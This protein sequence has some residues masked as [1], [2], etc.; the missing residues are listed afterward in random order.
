MQ[1]PNLARAYP[2]AQFKTSTVPYGDQFGITDALSSNMTLAAYVAY[3]DRILLAKTIA[4]AQKSN[5]N[6]DRTN[7]ASS[8]SITAIQPPQYI[9][10]K[11]SDDISVTSPLYQEIAAMHTP[12]V[13]T[14]QHSTVQFYLGAVGTGAPFHFHKDAYNVRCAFSDSNLHSRMPSDPTHVRIKRTCV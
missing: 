10:S 14:D 8:S 3:M 7:T 12:I 6:A 1:R 5:G 4:E 13:S 11:V 9:F 2:D